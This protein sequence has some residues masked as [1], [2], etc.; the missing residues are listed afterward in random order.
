MRLTDIG[1]TGLIERLASATRRDADGLLRGIGD[2]AAVIDWPAGRLLLA[3]CDTLIDGVHFRGSRSLPGLPEAGFRGI[4]RRAA[5]VNL[6]DIAAMGGRARFALVSLSAPAATEAEALEDLYAGLAEALGE[7]G[8]AVAGGNTALAPERLS[9][10]ICLLGQ[11]EPSHLLTR[12]GARPG[13]ALCVTGDLGAAATGLAVLDAATPGTTLDGAAREVALRH[14]APVPRL[15]AGTILG[16]SGAAT[17]CIDVSDGLLRD[18]GHLARASGV[19]IRIDVERIPLCGATREVCAAA[20]IDALEAAATG[21]ED[22]ELLCTVR[23]DGLAAL[24]RALDSEVGLPLT[25]IG[26]VVAGTPEAFAQRDGKRWRPGRDGFDHF[27]SGGT[28]EESS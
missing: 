13:D 15:A 21:G 16:A 9:L 10:D 23:P 6:S 28:R 5:A 4:G 27:L 20:D 19:S 22:Y 7:A 11:V 3:T 25:R 12:D 2:D 18:A 24:A 17:A 1:E 26:E 8:A 14:L